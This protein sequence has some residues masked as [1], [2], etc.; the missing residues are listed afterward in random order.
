LLL[1]VFL[2]I[3][4]YIEVLLIELK[5]ESIMMSWKLFWQ[6]VLLV[7]IAAIIFNL[8]KVGAMKAHRFIEG[9]TASS[10]T[11]K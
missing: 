11:H 10:C 9:K 6:I 8:T 1:P 5:G 7:V 4:C 2:Y 3:L